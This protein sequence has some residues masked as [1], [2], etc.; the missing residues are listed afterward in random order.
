MSEPVRVL[1]VASSSSSVELLDQPSSLLDQPSSLVVQPSS[2]AVSL[3]LQLE[4]PAVVQCA[5]ELVRG[6]AAATS[7][8]L[9]PG[10]DVLPLDPQA[11]LPDTQENPLAVEGTGIVGVV[12]TWTDPRDD[13]VL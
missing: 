7:F 10:P 11:G 13:V 4:V 12:G 6:E 3:L 1:E 9:Q 5:V 8:H 2:L